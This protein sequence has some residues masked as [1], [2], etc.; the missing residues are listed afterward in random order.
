M[1][2]KDYYDDY[3]KQ[4]YNIKLNKKTKHSHTVKDFYN[5]CI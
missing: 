3:K 1:D 2:I 5:D 4:N